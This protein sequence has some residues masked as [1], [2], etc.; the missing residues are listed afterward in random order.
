MWQQSLATPCDSR[1]GVFKTGRHRDCTDLFQPIDVTGC[2]ALGIRSSL[3]G[4]R[5]LTHRG[6]A[7]VFRAPS[8][9]FGV[10]ARAGWS[11]SAGGVADDLPEYSVEATTS[12]LLGAACLVALLAGCAPEELETA[13]QH[14]LP[15]R[16]AVRQVEAF[17]EKRETSYS[18]GSL[19]TDRT[20]RA[21]SRH[22]K[23]HLVSSYDIEDWVGHYDKNACWID[24]ARYTPVD[25]RVSCTRSTVMQPRRTA[26]HLTQAWLSSS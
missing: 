13:V 26:R 18:R 11:R 5:S 16:A 12:L 25:G 2:R 14:D 24:V 9:F 20:L 22:V 3:G 15:A 19:A 8:V 1:Y 7:Y 23:R 6:V 17:L 4:K 21:S 10:V